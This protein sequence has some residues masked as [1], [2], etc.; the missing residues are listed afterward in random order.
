MFGGL[1]AGFAQL[2]KPNPHT[3]GQPTEKRARRI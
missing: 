3:K 1:A 2:V